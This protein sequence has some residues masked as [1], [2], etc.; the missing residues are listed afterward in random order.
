MK[1]YL[2]ID[3]GSVTI[4]MATSNTGIIATSYKT[5]R[6]VKDNYEMAV[7]LILEVVK[8]LKIDIV[9]LGLPK[10]MN[11]DLGIR[12]EISLKVQ[13]ELLKKNQEISVILQ[14]ER[15]STKI[16]VKSM[17]HIKTNKKSVVKE[18]KDSLAAQVIL[19]NY[20]DSLK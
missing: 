2:G 15:L 14:D 8:E 7:T 10:H 16:A 12:G 4:G 19:Q 3:L 18:N 13:E 11:N 5:L 17:N 9:V 6:F 1:K 20:L